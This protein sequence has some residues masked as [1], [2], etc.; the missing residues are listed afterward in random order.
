MSAH[1]ADSAWVYGSARVSGSARV[2]GE[3]RVESN[4][5]IAWVDR[6]GSGHS[7]TLHRTVGGWRIN[8]ECRSWE[9]PTADEA[10]DMV[11]AHVA[12][13]PDEWAHRDDATRARWATQVV[14]ALTFLLASVDATRAAVT[15]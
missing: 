3:G 11:L 7:M 10:C 1:I 4:D 8:A 13:G 5:D 9:A 6:V 12:A 14:A 2:Y 15:R